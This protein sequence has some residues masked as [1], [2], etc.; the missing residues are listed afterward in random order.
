MQLGLVVPSGLPCLVRK[1]ICLCGLILVVHICQCYSLRD[2]CVYTC[3]YMCGCVFWLQR[4]YIF[5]IIML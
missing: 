4:E 2:V 5:L 3:V 1:W